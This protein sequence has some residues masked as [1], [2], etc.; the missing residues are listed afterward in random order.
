MERPGIQKFIEKDRTEW[1]LRS[2]YDSSPM[3]TVE[4]LK[5]E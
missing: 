5:F 2:F 1:I 4:G 3:V